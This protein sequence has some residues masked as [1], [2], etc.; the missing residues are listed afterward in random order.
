[1]TAA[2]MAAVTNE[3]LLE[4]CRRK[5]AEE[6]RRERERKNQW[7]ELQPSECEL[8]A[9]K[10]QPRQQQQ[11]PLDAATAAEPSAPVPA[12]ALRGARL[13]AT[14]VAA[15]AVE[16]PAPV[17]SL[18]DLFG[19]GTDLDLPLPAPASTVLPPP[20]AFDSQQQRQQQQQE[21]Q[22]PS[23]PPPPPLPLQPPQQ[24]QTQQQSRDNGGN[25][26]GTAQPSSSGEAGPIS[27][28]APVAAPT[29]GPQGSTQANGAPK[30]S[31]RERM[32]SL[33]GGGQ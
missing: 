5:L 20:A 14:P 27:L 33:C 29:R 10:E 22:S 17:T 21:Q 3:E 7:S 25:A 28:Q 16:A 24:Q 11:H 6:A 18:F 15:P 32:A 13:E 8:L 4:L 30:R 23:L 1:M 2:E 26:L 9:A 31:L 19:L 12:T